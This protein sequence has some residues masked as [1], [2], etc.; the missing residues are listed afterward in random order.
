MHAIHVTEHGGPEVLEW[1]EVPPLEPGEAELVVAIMAAGVNYVEIYHRSGI[2][3]REPPFVLGGEGAGRVVAVGAGAGD[4]SV[5][6][7][8]ASTS[9]YGSYAE[10]SIVSA[11][12]AVAVPQGMDTEVAA[13]VLLQGM[14]AHY[15]CLDSYP[16][17][18]GDLC[19]IHAGAGGVGGLLIQMAK[20][21]GA[22]VFTTVSTSVKAELAR[23][24]G[25]DH[26][27]NYLEEDFVAAVEHVAGPKALAAVYDGV[28]AT[29]FERG[30]SLLRPRGT[31]V[32]FGQSSGAVPPLDLGTLATGGSLYVTRPTLAT[33]V[34]S[35]E[36]LE[37][38]AAD[39][40]SWIADGSL[41]VRIGQR[42]P[43]S[44]AAQAHSDLEGRRTTGKILLIS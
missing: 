12:R 19:L 38:R 18:P 16:L 27:I 9:F 36:D 10:S 1:T 23:G 8:V 3:K 20:T 24:A 17:A 41:D 7:L 15:L 29:T 28:G 37:R 22:T 44:A 6:D 21:L 34:A 43:L 30:L 2:Y 4:F 25:A 13:A 40:F 32:L 42:Y 33:H 11:E 35:R 39:L 26:V 31:M 14:T 5:G